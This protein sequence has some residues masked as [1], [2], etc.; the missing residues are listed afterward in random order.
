MINKVVVFSEAEVCVTEGCVLAG[1]S[2]IVE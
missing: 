2:Y 1:K